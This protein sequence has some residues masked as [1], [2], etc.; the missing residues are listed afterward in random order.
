MLGRGDCLGDLGRG[1]CLGDLISLNRVDCCLAAGIRPFSRT[2]LLEYGCGGDTLP[3]FFR[4]VASRI[5]LVGWYSK[6][7]H[8]AV[9]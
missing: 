5:S 6:E 3:V 7:M 2:R 4:F 8:L 1:D 9:L